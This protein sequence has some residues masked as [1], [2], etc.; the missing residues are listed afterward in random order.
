MWEEDLE[1]GSRQKVAWLIGIIA[2]CAAAVPV[3]TPALCVTGATPAAWLSGIRG[4]GTGK[5]W[6]THASSLVG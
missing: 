4:V 6:V 5:V 1:D 2:A 3:T